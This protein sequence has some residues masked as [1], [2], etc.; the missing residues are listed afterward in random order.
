MGEL[1]IELKSV[2]SEIL[3]KDYERAVENYHRKELEIKR[4][5]H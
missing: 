4:Y 1:E 2:R 3:E 5:R